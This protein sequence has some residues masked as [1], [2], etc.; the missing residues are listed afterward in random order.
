MCRPRPNSPS[1][2]SPLIFDQFPRIPSSPVFHR[3]S[4][5]YTFIHH[6]HLFL[7]FLQKF[8]NRGFFY[9]RFN[10]SSDT[11]TVKLVII[12]HLYYASMYEGYAKDM[13]MRKL[14]SDFFVLSL[15]S[16]VLI[17]SVKRYHVNVLK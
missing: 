7:L 17:S 10:V 5:G 12:I 13:E 15:A 14:F 16:N 1:P 8:N 2:S 4:I 11:V 6:L 9:S 3:S